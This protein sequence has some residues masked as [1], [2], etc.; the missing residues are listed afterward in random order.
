MDKKRINKNKDLLYENS[1]SL[2]TEAA[3]TLEEDIFIQRKIYWKS[4]WWRGRVGD[5]KSVELTDGE[6]KGQD[7]WSFY[8]FGGS[9]PGAP[10]FD[11]SEIC[12]GVF[13]G[14]SGGHCTR[15]VYMGQGNYQNWWH[16]QIWRV[17]G[18]LTEDSQHFSWEGMMHCMTVW[19][20]PS[21][22]FSF[23]YFVHLLLI[24]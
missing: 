5:S 23:Y 24:L 12:G 1:V 16:L 10:I 21:G 6:R 22:I 13:C 17:F 14:F 11:L 4:V 8:T 3:L 7:P 2:A 15:G 20:W 18:A 19:L 9:A